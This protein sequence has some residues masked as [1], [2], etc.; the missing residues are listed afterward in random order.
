MGAKMGRQLKEKNLKDRE[1]RKKL[2]TRSEP[3]WRLLESGL[4]L[5]YRKAPKGGA[6]VGRRFT[7]ARQYK[8][9]RLGVADDAQDAAAFGKIGNAKC[10]GERAIVGF[11]CVVGNWVGFQ[12][13]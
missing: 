9:V 8:E 4:H 12:S 5:G 2:P 1:A 11:A 7:E 10:F 3:H 13:R 6:W